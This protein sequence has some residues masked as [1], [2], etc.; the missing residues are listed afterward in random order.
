[1]LEADD[2]DADANLFGADSD[3]DAVYNDDWTERHAAL[4]VDAYDDDWADPPAL[5]GPPAVAAP[6]DDYDDDWN[7]PI[8][9]PAPPLQGV[10]IGAP[11]PDGPQPSATARRV[12]TRPIP[13]SRFGTRIVNV[14]PETKQ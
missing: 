8:D 6:A 13:P 7:S 12:L 9:H 1:M 14:W 10:A 4:S 3:P 2:D 5:F 11:R